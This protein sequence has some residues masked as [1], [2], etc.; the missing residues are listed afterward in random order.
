MGLFAGG[1]IRSHV[2]EGVRGTRV[3]PYFGAIDKELDAHH[4]STGGRTNGSENVAYRPTRQRG[5]AV[6]DGSR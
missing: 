4:G 1:E 2:A 3:F 6:G 5:D